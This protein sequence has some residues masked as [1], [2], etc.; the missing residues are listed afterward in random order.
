MYIIKTLILIQIHLKPVNLWKTG[1]KRHLL[2]CKFIFFRP[3]FHDYA[4]PVKFKYI[5]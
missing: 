1:M 5:L 3:E 2:K 4:S